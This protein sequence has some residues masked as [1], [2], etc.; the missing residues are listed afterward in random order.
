MTVEFGD[1]ILT[2]FPSKKQPVKFDQSIIPSF[3]SHMA[4]S[5]AECK[6][7][8]INHLRRQDTLKKVPS[9]FYFEMVS[10][11][12]DHNDVFVAKLK[13]KL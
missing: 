9:G 8:E 6:T 11:Q 13:H 7:Y 10:C 2:I 12:S 1:D 3:Q 5:I 4:I